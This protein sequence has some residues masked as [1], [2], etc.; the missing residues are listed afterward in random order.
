MEDFCEVSRKEKMTYVNKLS[1][2]REL[3]PSTL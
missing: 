1:G 3:A 2:G